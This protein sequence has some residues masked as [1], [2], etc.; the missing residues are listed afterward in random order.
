MRQSSPVSPKRQ[1]SP[2]VTLQRASTQP[3]LEQI[4]K[5]AR[6]SIRRLEAQQ[7]RAQRVP[8]WW[9]ATL[10]VIYPGSLG[11]DETVADLCTRG[12]SSMLSTCDPVWDC[13]TDGASW[14]FV[15][16]VA[17]AIICGLASALFWMRIV[18]QQHGQNG[19]LD[20][21]HGGATSGSS[22]CI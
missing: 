17:F 15:L 19:R 7:R 21:C 18:Y 6:E 1:V 9:A 22:G 16:A 10:V 5:F 14:V 3:K 20:V 8:P 12:Y 13:L 11:L 4:D 2:I